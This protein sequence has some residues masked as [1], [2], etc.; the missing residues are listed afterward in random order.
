MLEDD[1]LRY[2]RAAHAIQSGVAYEMNTTNAHE[3]KHLRVGVNMAMVS[4]GAL[5]E[6]LIDKGVISLDEYH[7]AL[8]DAAEE[9][10]AR[11]EARAK[12]RI[13][14]GAKINFR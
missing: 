12:Q 9:E 11:Y 3:P 4:H 7:K 13:G 6:L 10:V 8:A 5:V 2:E 1:E 14:T